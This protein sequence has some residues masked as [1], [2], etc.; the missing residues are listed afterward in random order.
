LE[1]NLIG[2]DTFGVNFPEKN[3]IHVQILSEIEKREN[4]WGYYSV[5]G[6]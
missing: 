2:L 4:N 3:L 1:K 6:F 5:Y